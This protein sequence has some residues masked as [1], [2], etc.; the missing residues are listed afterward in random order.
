MVL[1]LK[2]APRVLL[3]EPDVEMQ[4]KVTL[5]L[6][7]DCATGAATDAASA[8]ILHNE[9]PADLVLANIMTSP[10]DGFAAVSEIRRNTQFNAVPVIVYSSPGTEEVC[11]ELM[12]NG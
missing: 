3:I 6:E 4:R 8:I 9:T 5:M 12:D 2:N 1:I 7:P 11:L 10:R